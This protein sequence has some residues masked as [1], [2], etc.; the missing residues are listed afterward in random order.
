MSARLEI[1]AII[2]L[3]LADAADCRMAA[4]MNG[5]YGDNGAKDLETQVKFFYYGQNNQIPKEWSKYVDQAKKNADPDYAA[6]L[7]LKEK[8]GE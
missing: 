6:F 8:F 7:K 1:E 5:S 2:A 4:G 3:V